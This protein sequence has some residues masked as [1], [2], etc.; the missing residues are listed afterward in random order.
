MP[1]PKGSKAK[2]AP[3]AEAPVGDIAVGSSIRFLGYDASVP[4][5]DRVL[6]EGEVYEVVELPGEVDGEATGFVV[7]KPNPKFNPKK[8]AND[9]T[10]PE[11]QDV[12]VFEEEIELADDAIE[13]ELVQPE[14][15]E[16]LP[17]D[18]AYLETAE[19]AELVE[20]AKENNIKLTAT[21]K[22]STEAMVAVIAKALELE[23]V[24]EEE[25]EE[26]QPEGED[27]LPID[28]EYLQSLSKEELIALAKEQEVKLTPAQ[29]KT[30][31]TLVD[32]LADAF[33]L[34]A[35]EEQPEPAPE[36]APKKSTAKAKADA[37]PA[38]KAS[39]KA[40]TK[41][42]AKAASKPAPTPAT[43]E[44]DEFPE[45]ENE[46]ES[47][48]ALVAESKD[49]VETAQELES[50][51]AANEFRL[52]GVL[53]HLKKEGSWKEAGKQ[54]AENGGWALFVKDHFNVDYRKAQYLI[55]IYVHLTLAGIENP[56]EV[57]GNIGWTKA[58]KIAKHMS[59][60]DIDPLALIE[61]AESNTVEDLSTVLKE[62]FH[63]GGTAGEKG[64]KKTRITLKF[65]YVEEQAKIVEDVLTVAAEQLGGSDEDAL[66][67]ILSQWA[68]ENSVETTAAKAAE[69]DTAKTTAKPA[70]SKP[71]TT[72]RRAVA[73][74]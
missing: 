12:E 47:V 10:N 64:E 32:A 13:G 8:A 54:Y 37:K 1:A 6:T 46:D 35:E 18:Y 28:L 67:Q 4:E 42:A 5:E 44:E 15:E 49:L 19:A 2:A 45:L 74:A 48:L 14:G 27:D 22:K 55:E 40:A 71:A 30:Q 26:E 53:F 16:E 36:P 33:D 52:G 39:T 62:D 65:R 25:Q 24:E 50:E 60:P 7:R 21:Q 43:T 61:A 70:A 38:A 23:P 17:I 69:K 11:F 41:P 51:N 20:I 34:P 68:V 29:K 31:G 63:I 72:S 73:K 56:S 58:S 59:N 57:I 3:A 66:F 9:K